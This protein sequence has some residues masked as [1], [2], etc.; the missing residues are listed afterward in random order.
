MEDGLKTE[1]FEL[2]LGEGGRGEELT[3]C[4]GGRYFSDVLKKR[5]QTR[6]T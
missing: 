6:T 5:S 1:E 4:A 3:H 2:E